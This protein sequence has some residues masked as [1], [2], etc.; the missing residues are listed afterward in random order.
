M[1]DLAEH[2][3]EFERREAFAYSVLASS[4]CIGCVYIEPW[5]CG[6]QLAYWVTDDAIAI[7]SDIVAGVLAWLTLW[8]FD[9]VVV[10]L[11][12]ENVRGRACLQ[13]LGLQPCPGPPG[14]ISF[15]QQ[16]AVGDGAR[17]REK[18]GR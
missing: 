2:Q 1:A 12:P 5:T 4:R 14:H 10:P 17:A 11:R 7:E 16:K 18:P 8:P 13:G 15:S 6:A 9:C 3:A